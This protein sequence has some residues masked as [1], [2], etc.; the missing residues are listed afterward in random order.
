MTRSSSKYPITAG[1]E[2][3]PWQEASPVM[4]ASLTTS[5]STSRDCRSASRRREYQSGAGRPRTTPS[6]TL[7]RLLDERCKWYCRD[8]RDTGPEN[9]RLSVP[10]LG[11]SGPATG[12]GRA[13]LTTQCRRLLLLLFNRAS[14]GNPGRRRHDSATTSA[15]RQLRGRGD[16]AGDKRLPHFAHRHKARRLCRRSC[17]KF[18]AE[19]LAGFRSETRDPVPGG[20]ATCLPTSS[21]GARVRPGVREA[22]VAAEEGWPRDLPSAL[23]S[24]RRQRDDPNGIFGSSS[25]TSTHTTSAIAGAPA[26]NCRGA[27]DSRPLPAPPRSSV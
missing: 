7:F 3:S 12:H 22:D 24:A 19:P 16:L 15:P 10:Y 17:S 23:P 1:F 5:W 2:S 9:D 13:S 21:A 4:Q 18:L 26:P 27:R 11:E 25:Q 6:S 14:T 20:T 8:D